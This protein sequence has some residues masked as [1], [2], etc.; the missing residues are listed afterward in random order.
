MKDN[1]SPLFSQ[2][3]LDG[4]QMDE[5]PF[6]ALYDCL[7]GNGTVD[8]PKG[9]FQ[10]IVD[11]YM[12]KKPVTFQYDP[13]KSLEYVEKILQAPRNRKTVNLDYPL[14]WTK[15]AIS[16]LLLECLFRDGHFTLQ[17]IL[18][19]AKWDWNNAPAG[20]MAAFYD[21]TVAAGRYL[22]DLGVKLDRY[23]VE[24]NSR[25]CRFDLEVRS[26]MSSRRKCPDTVGA[27]PRDWLIY[28]PFDNG[29]FCLGGSALSNVVGGG[30]GV[31][32]DVQDPD[33]FIDCYEVVREL[34]EDGVICA[35]VPVGYGGL[36]TAA[37]KFRGRRGLNLEIG[38]IMSAKGETDPVKILF[39]ETPGVIIEIKDDDYDYLDAQLLLQEA[40]Y[41]PIGHPDPES[42]ELS[43]SREDRNNVVGIL[44]SL[45]GIS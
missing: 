5:T 16:N 30:S 13:D 45:M 41:Y 44:N 10:D 29:R 14:S 19:M 20:N 2:Y 24:S 21:S 9:P 34:V 37:E 4:V 35:G 36:A 1:V 8:V 32:G 15:N 43:I 23:F 17:D 6:S 39:A 42:H 26:R 7:D 28:I 25:E 38:G 40:A 12:D 3:I 18:L 33:Y 11:E 31:E 22:F 27:D